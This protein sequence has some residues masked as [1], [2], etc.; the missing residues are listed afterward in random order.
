MDFS[1]FVKSLLLILQDLSVVGGT[2]APLI[3]VSL[4]LWYEFF[5][6]IVLFLATIDVRLFL[7]GFIVSVVGFPS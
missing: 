6:Y 4:I 7:G 5:F 3:V 1:A 2:G